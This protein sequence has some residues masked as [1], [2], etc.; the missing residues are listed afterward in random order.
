MNY[1]EYSEMGEVMCIIKEF[2]SYM[3]THHLELIEKD[4]KVDVKQFSATE[5]NSR[6]LK[7]L[8]LQEINEPIT[9]WVFF[10]DNS[11]DEVVLFLQD[12]RRIKNIAISLL[13]NGKPVKPMSF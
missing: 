4:W 8:L 13:R 3:K 5:L 10:H 11:Y 9:C 6:N 12:K 2:R 7:T 1:N